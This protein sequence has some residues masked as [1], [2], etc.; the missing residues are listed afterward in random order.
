MEDKKRCPYCDELIRVS[1]IKCKHC[2]STLTNIS[3]DSISVTP[4]TKIRMAL[5]DKYEIM[6]EV[7]RGG[8][9]TVYK[10]LQKSLNRV[11]GL[12][13]IHQNLVHDKEFLE[14]FHREA[15]IAAAISH[16]NI[17]TVY[18]EGHTR[19][20]HYLTM[21][22]IDG[23]DLL[24]L[25]KRKKKLTVE[26]IIKIFVPIAEAL[27]HIHKKGLIHRDIKTSNIIITSE[28]RPILT[29]FGIAHAASSSKLT[30]T[31]T[32]IGTPEYM[33][34]EQAEGRQVDHRSDIYSLG[35]V[36]YECLSGR[37]PFKGE[38][39]ISTIYKILHEPLI[40]I[41]KK[42]STLPLWLSDVTSK[43]LAKDAT[44]RFQNGSVLSQALQNR[45]GAQGL[46]GGGN[47][48]Y[49]QK[50]VKYRLNEKR[51]GSNNKVKLTNTISKKQ[52]IINF[53]L[54]GAIV[55]LLGILAS[56][57]YERGL[58]S[59]DSGLLEGCDKENL[60]Q[61]ELEQIKL[62]I[63]EADELYHS[64]KIIEP[65]NNN[66][67]TNYRD[68]LKICPYNVYAQKQ[69]NRIIRDLELSIEQAIKNNNLELAKRISSAAIAYFPT[70]DQFLIIKNQVHTTADISKLKALVEQ[71]LDSAYA[72]CKGLLASDPENYTIQN[73]FSEI[74]TRY[75]ASADILYTANKWYEA[76]RAYQNVIDKY[77]PDTRIQSRIEDS[78]RQIVSSRRVSIP[79]VVGMSVDEARS[80]LQNSELI[81]GNIS[82]IDRPDAVNKII[83]IIPPPGSSVQ[84]G[85]SVG[86]IIGQ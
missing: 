14:R 53:I 49:P 70:S 59:P 63:Q 20:I 25:V 32:V 8:M 54:V 10:A 19:G 35:V 79:N 23:L 50:T 28:G 84:R 38:N 58:F 48:K 80:I 11:V 33:S 41:I 39:P 60:T 86:I 1:A 67:I 18:D 74:K 29:D 46:N 2:G 30:K 22:F 51:K 34:P 4:E 42:D 16:P 36:I 12:K 17:L 64:G 45:I 85:T 65:S 27:D 61:S 75:I 40:P 24:K 82:R 62:G 56:L 73:I 21:E 47:I 72:L 57:L 3:T 7:G 15:Q 76:R 83:R 5:A 44:T 26:E 6:E 31:G 77:G 43:L 69:L 68:I 81:I 37:V 71:N 9:A 78:N 66:A 52:K 55:I 13:V